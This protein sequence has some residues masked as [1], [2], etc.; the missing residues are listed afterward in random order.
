MITGSGITCED[1]RLEFYSA[2]R[3]LEFGTT[4]SPAFN[5]LADKLE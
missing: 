5:A 4:E 2:A 3:R 1:D